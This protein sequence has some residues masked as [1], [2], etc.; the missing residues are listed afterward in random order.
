VD[1]SGYHMLDE[2]RP[3]DFCMHAKGHQRASKN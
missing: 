1:R 2:A 3:A